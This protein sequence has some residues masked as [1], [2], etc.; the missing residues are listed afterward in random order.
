MQVL[1]SMMGLAFCGCLGDGEITGLSNLHSSLIADSHQ[2]NVVGG[3][4][5]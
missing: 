4:G 3:A 1:P 5:A 2:M